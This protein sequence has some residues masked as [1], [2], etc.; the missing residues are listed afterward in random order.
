VERV[1]REAQAQRKRAQAAEQAL[2]KREAEDRAREEAAAVEAGEWRKLAET[3]AAELAERDKRDAEL[4]L[5]RKR[6]TLSSAIQVEIA[7]RLPAADPADKAAVQA[8]ENRARMLSAL[9]HTELGE[10]AFDE[11]GKV[12]SKNVQKVASTV[13]ET[14]GVTG[15]PPTQGRPKLK[16]RSVEVDAASPKKSNPRAENRDLIKG[17]L[18]EKAHEGF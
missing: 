6:E 9:I 14:F 13:F 5:E 16:D 15:K 17:F 4:T 8:R 1:R 2:A 11:A 18:S 3:R 7:S 12:A 10:S